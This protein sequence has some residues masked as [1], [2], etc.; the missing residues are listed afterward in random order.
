MNL[1]DF[2]NSYVKVDQEVSDAEIRNALNLSKI[3]NIGL[4]FLAY[5]YSN[6]CQTYK[7][8]RDSGFPEYFMSVSGNKVL[9]FPEGGYFG[10]I[11]LWYPREISFFNLIQNPIMAGWV[12][13]DLLRKMD[14]IE[15][16]INF[17]NP[18]EIMKESI[19]NL[20]TEIKRTEFY[21][22]WIGDPRNSKRKRSIKLRRLEVVEAK[23]ETKMCYSS[24][25]PEIKMRDKDT[26]EEFK[27][28]SYNLDGWEFYLSKEL[29]ASRLKDLEI[30]WM[31]GY[32]QRVKSLEYKIKTKKK[33]LE[34]LIIERK[35]FENGITEYQ[36]KLHELLWKNF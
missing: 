30:F 4:E 35:E 3:F 32:D 1:L 9:K 5:A 22:F 33:E 36:K 34:N 11:D 21:G 16:I 14:K 26:H 25:F 12:I 24:L 6:N 29:M 10:V 2:Y 13:H 20:L 19:E 27:F 8:Y 23:L 7:R 15:D 28:D 17:P 18:S 31:R